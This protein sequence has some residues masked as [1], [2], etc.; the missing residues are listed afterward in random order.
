MQGSRRNENSKRVSQ[1]LFLRFFLRYPPSVKKE[2][3]EKKRLFSL[4]SCGLQNKN[5][6]I[7]RLLD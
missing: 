6:Y 1:T 5:I 7:P 3:N 4:S 2:V